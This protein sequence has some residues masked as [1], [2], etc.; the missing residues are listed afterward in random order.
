M[1]RARL[2][3]LLVQLLGFA[4]VAWFLADTVREHWGT[5]ARADIVPAAGPLLLASAITVGTYLGLVGAWTV[6]MRWWDA[7]LPY[8]DA[9]RVWFFTN[10]ARFV[11]GG[12]WQFAGLTA[13]AVA[14]GVSPLAASGAVILQQVVLLGTGIALALA[15]MPALFGSWAASLP[16]W[17][18]LPIAVLAVGIVILVLPRILPW[19]GGLAERLV[20]RRVPWPRPPAGEWALYVTGLVV[21]WLAYGLAFWLFGRAFLG[22]A[23]PGFMLAFGAYTSSYVAGIILVFAPGGIVVRE[24]ALVAALGPHIGAENALLLAFGARL[25]QIGLEIVTAL[26][27]ALFVRGSRA[28]SRH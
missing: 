3:T 15:L 6:C 18:P 27:V 16:E 4:G 1:T 8:R 9:V 7:R 5:V 23:A 14:L 24:T 21:P 19:T 13:M 25:W 26:G 10:L 11:P 12:V 20:R 22:D 2:L 28:D 17:A